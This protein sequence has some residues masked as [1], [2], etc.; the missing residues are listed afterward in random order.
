MKARTVATC[1]WCYMT[2][3]RDVEFASTRPLLLAF[4]CADCKKAFSALAWLE[5]RCKEYKLEAEETS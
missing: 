5:V 3:V 1:P 4:S 2:V